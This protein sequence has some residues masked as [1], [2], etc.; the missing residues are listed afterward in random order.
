MKARTGLPAFANS[1]IFSGR[2]ICLYPL[3]G[4]AMRVA[5]SSGQRFCLISASVTCTDRVIDKTTTSAVF[6][7]RRL[8][9]PN[10]T[11]ALANIVIA[12][13]VSATILSG[14][15]TL[16][17]PQHTASTSQ[18][19]VLSVAD[20]ND[21]FPA[22]DWFAQAREVVGTELETDL[23]H[24]TLSYTDAEGIASHAKI[25]LMAALSHD[26][27]DNYFTE[28]L[29]DNILTTQTESVL[30][31]Y[32]PTTKQILLHEENLDK[33]LQSY[34]GK[35]EKALQALVIHELVH[36]A[37]DIR[38]DVF[39][40]H[41]LQYQEVFA[42]SAVIEGHAQWQTR[43]ICKQLQCSDAFQQLNKY[44]FDTA[45][46]DDPAL[47]YVQNRSF[48]NLEFV[49]KEG[50]RFIDE[51]KQRE[52]GDSLITLAFENPPRDSVQIIDPLSFPNRDRES[53]N[54]FLSDT[55]EDS[56]KPWQEHSTGSLKRNVLAAASFSVDPTSRQPIVD[57]YTSKILAAAKHEYY[58]HGSDTTIPVAV[59]ALQTDTDTTA[60]KTASLIFNSTINTYDKL[61]GD[62]VEIENWNQEQHSAEVQGSLSG[63]G[64]IEMHT[65]S[66]YIRNG[67]V[68]AEYPVEVVTAS[69]GSFLVHID[70]RYNH[71]SESLMQFAGRLLLSLQEN[72]LLNNAT[73]SRS[74]F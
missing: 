7:F 67:L 22:K 35:P 47:Q 65:A 59:I 46:P 74:D 16:S 8:F 66:G 38:H 51:L 23:S 33:Y 5:L 26:L 45:T 21:E 70:G 48:K 53:R 64:H 41:A 58:E 52:N 57:F 42:K 62:L 27:G 39:N 30:A 37:D 24:V 12:T 31:I 13:L 6:M 17:G 56:V 19:S 15:A 55:V 32:S 50:E 68:G 14:C 9:R 2:E 4:I 1:I 73:A 71:G 69:S 3:S 36:S 18:E 61:R 29:V 25:S 63:S 40:Q 54:Q 72:E 28:S 20:T 11:T 43:R 44:M 34:T 49:Y 60:K 10:D